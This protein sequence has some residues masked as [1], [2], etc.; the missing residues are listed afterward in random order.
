MYGDDYWVIHPLARPDL[1]ALLENPIGALRMAALEAAADFAALSGQKP[2][3]LRPYRLANSR[4][5][6]MLKEVSVGQQISLFFAKQGETN[7]RVHLVLLHIAHVVGPSQV[8]AELLVAEGR[9]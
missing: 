5:Y 2:S 7:G 4:L 9:Q 8:H 1:R 6:R 3:L